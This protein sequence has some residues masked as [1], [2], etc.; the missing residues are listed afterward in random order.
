MRRW[1][2]L[3][4]VLALM[5]CETPVEP[6]NVDTDDDQDQTVTVIVNVGGDHTHS[7]G[8]DE[9]S[10]PVIRNPGTQFYAVGD[11]IVLPINVTDADNDDVECSL[12]GAPRNLAIDESTQ[13]ITGTITSSSAAESP[14]VATVSCTDGK[15]FD[16]EQFI[17]NVAAPEPEG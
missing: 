8:D 5:G 9:N 14:F 10:P 15:V 4:A 17:I 6:S 3:V 16:A 11:I 13:L 12:D 1:W 7:G 2:V